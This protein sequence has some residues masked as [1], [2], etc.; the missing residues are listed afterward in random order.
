MIE[1]GRIVEEDITED[2]LSEVESIAA[3]LDNL[4]DSDDEIV[5]FRTNRNK[6]LVETNKTKVDQYIGGRWAENVRRDTDIEKEVGHE[7]F[8]FGEDLYNS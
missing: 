6:V 1:G 2:D 4:S 3:S 5:K 8:L 7:I